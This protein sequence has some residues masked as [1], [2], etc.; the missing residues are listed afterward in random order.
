M[1]LGLAH[2]IV[3]GILPPDPVQ[4]FLWMALH[5]LEHFFGGGGGP[6]PELPPLT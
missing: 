1:F 2:L 4:G 5:G 6:P 3:A